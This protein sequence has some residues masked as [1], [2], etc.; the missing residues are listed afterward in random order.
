MTDKNNQINGR[1]PIHAYLEPDTHDA[2]HRT[3][4][5]HRVS[6]AAL[7]EALGPE[8]AAI[9]KARPQLVVLAGQVDARRRARR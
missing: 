5:E 4:G 7:L 2:W 9:L 1:R 6:V 3:A 8:L